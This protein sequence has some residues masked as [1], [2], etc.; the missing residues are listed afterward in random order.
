MTTIKDV[1]KQAGVSVATVSCALSGK[2]NVSHRARIKIME[3]IEK[4][5]YIPNESARRLKLR[6][7]REIGILLTSIDDIYQSEILKGIISVIQENDYTVNISFSNNQPKTEMEIINRFIS[8]NY[9]GII[10]SSCMTGTQYFQKLLSQKIPV[11]FIENRP[12]NPDVNFAGI[13]VKKTIDFLAENLIAAGYTDK[14][15]LFCGNPDIS[16]ENDC[17]ETFK[18]AFRDC[19]DIFVNFTTMTKEDSFRIAL[20]TLEETRPKAIITTSENIAHGILEGAKVL[21]LPIPLI[22][23]FSEETWIETKYLSSVVHTSRPAFRLG[24]SA[25]SLLLKSIQGQKNE[26]LLFD[27]NIVRAGISLPRPETAPVVQETPGR[28]D[29][30]ELSILMMD[31]NLAHAISVL[32]RKFTNEFNI[33]IRIETCIQNKLPNVILEDSFSSVPKY[34]IFMFDIPWL[35]FLAQNECLED[36]TGFITEDISFHNSII[37][38]NLVNSLYQ[39]HYYSIPIFG[40]AQL[41][42]YRTDLFEDPIICKDYFSQNGKKLQPPRTW[43]EFITVARFF[44]REYNRSSPVEFGT[45]CPGIMAEEFCPEVYIR[46]WGYNGALFSENNEP[47]LDTKQNVRAFENIIETQRYTPRP[48]FETSIINSVEDFYTGKTAM[49]I[50]YTEYA[51]KIMDA[52]NRSVFGKLMFTFVPQR[53]PLSV[54]WNLGLNPYSPKKEQAKIFF[55][56]L[57]RKDVNYYLTILD[58]QTTSIHP[59]ENNELLKLYPWMAITRENFKFTRKRITGDRENSIII[60]W[61]RIE[62][63]IYSSAKKMFEENNISRCLGEANDQIIRLQSMY[64]YV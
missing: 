52:I 7:S 44:T 36:L 33:R 13:T 47:R 15:V 28:E 2:K 23:T 42:F 63:I 60:P 17:A 30:G 12:K 31:C 35:N 11:V 19:K 3:A 34:D 5:G 20:S 27:D 1:A 6:T 40:G 37:K 49:L 53:T 14:I 18:K 50:T 62:N 61:N 9:A 57:Y 55:K 25:A 21:N 29:Q 10:L 41:L 58:G 39:K 48:L 4:L 43:N 22:I 8:R 59:Y 32:S 64:G 16:S 51:T 45:S 56:W 24:A 46:L 26:I 38:D 54:G